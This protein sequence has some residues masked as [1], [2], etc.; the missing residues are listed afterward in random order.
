MIILY[1]QLFSF[2]FL[3]FR[4]KKNNFHITEL[5]HIYWYDDSGIFLVHNLYRVEKV[6]LILVLLVES[7][8]LARFLL[9]IS[10]SICTFFW[11]LAQFI[12]FSLLFFVKEKFGSL[13]TENF[14]STLKA[15]VWTCVHVLL[16]WCKWN[17]VPFINLKKKF[18]SFCI[19]NKLMTR[20]MRFSYLLTVTF[21]L[22]RI[23]TDEFIWKPTFF[24]LYKRRFY[25]FVCFKRCTLYFCC[26]CYI[27]FLK[28]RTEVPP[29]GLK[30]NCCYDKKKCWIEINMVKWWKLETAI[31]AHFFGCC[32]NW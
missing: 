24:L 31:L 30:M 20:I 12:Y 4:S 13:W 9:N 21:W 25:S 15:D 14:Y 16:D 19:M 5:A 10:H 7:K 17:L 32:E 6:F 28:R 2:R 26:C 27:S 11:L 1:L 18:N 3:F 23:F 29:E 8:M 22:V